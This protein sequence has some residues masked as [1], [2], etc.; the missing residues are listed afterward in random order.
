MFI[1]YSQYQTD[2]LLRYVNCG[3]DN[4]LNPGDSLSM[5][6][7]IKVSQQSVNDNVKILGK[8]GPEFNSGYLLGKEASELYAEVWNP[9]TRELKAGFMPPMGP[10]MPF[11]GPQGPKILPVSGYR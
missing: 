5:E 3:A 7:W 11:F 9:T 1:D 4:S 6:A 2:G 8:V 10:L